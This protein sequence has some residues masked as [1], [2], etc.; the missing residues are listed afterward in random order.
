MIDDSVLLTCNE[1]E[2]LW[3]ARTQGIGHLKRGLPK[4]LL[5]SIVS[6]REIPKPE[7]FAGTNYTRKKLEDYITANYGQVRS[8]LPGCDGKCSVFPCTEG[9]HGA[10]FIPNREAV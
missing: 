10:C 2:L 5:A 1:T 3:M 9:R 7:H 8:Q 4:D 6:G